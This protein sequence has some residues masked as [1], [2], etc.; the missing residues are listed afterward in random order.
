MLGSKIPGAKCIIWL[1]DCEKNKRL[2]FLVLLEDKKCLLR[3]AFSKTMTVHFFALD[4]DIFSVPRD[5]MMRENIYVSFIKGDLIFEEA[6]EKRIDATTLVFNT[7]CKAD[8]SGNLPEE[9]D[10]SVPLA[11]LRSYF[12]QSAKQIVRAIRSIMELSQS[13]YVIQE[14]EESITATLKD[15]FLEFDIVSKTGRLEDDAKIGDDFIFSFALTD[16]RY[17]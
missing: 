17:S 12:A 8:C 9:G 11:D 6:L 13:E 2:S 7:I 16:D 15:L 1:L 14:A 4:E 3:Y 10:V 5:K